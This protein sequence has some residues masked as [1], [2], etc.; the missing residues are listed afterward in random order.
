MNIKKIISSAVAALALTVPSG[1]FAQT[2]EFHQKHVY[3]WDTIHRA[4]VEILLNDPKHCTSEEQDGAYLPQSRL[5]VICQDNARPGGPQVRWTANDYDTLR[6]EAH[7]IIQDCAA[8]DG[9]GGYSVTLFDREGLLTFVNQSDLTKDQIE[10]I[11]K[12]Y[13]RQGHPL[14]VVAMEVE[15]FVTASDVG[16]DLIAEKLI[17]TCA[18]R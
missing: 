1:A 4:G 6:H 11:I 10:R 18:R 2:N 17:Q 13:Q 5:L 16:A 3:L 7:H 15:A 8:G 9:L 12:S 14:N